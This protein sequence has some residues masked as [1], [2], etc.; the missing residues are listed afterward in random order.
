M[1]T[2]NSDESTDANTTAKQEAFFHDIENPDSPRWHNGVQAALHVGYSESCARSIAWKLWQDPEKRKRRLEVAKEF[3][4]RVCLSP[5]V[6]LTGLER[7]RQQAEAKGDLAVAARC[8][9]LMG[10]HLAMFTDKSMVEQIGDDETKRLTEKSKAEQEALERLA[11][12]RLR[13]VG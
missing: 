13:E 11:N 7:L 9:E 4:E 8:L 10:K 1:T 6:V 5:S 12:L 2:N 3:A